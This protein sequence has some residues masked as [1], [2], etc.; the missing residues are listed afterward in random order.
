MPVFW[1]AVTAEA[2]D[3]ADAR[4]DIMTLYGEMP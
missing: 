2:F 4:Y 1:R 3:I